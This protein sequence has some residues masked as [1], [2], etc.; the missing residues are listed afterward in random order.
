MAISTAAMRINN[1]VY[2]IV[3]LVL[4]LFCIATPANADGKQYKLLKI[5]PS[6]TEIIIGGKARGEG[7]VF[8]DGATIKWSSEDQ[9]IRTICLDNNKPQSFTAKAFKD[10]KAYSIAGYF[11]NNKMSQM[12]AGGLWTVLKGVVD[13]QRF[14]EKRIALVVGNSNYSSDIISSLTNPL[15]DASAVSKHLQSLGFDVWIAYDSK[16]DEFR[17][18]VDDFRKAVDNNKY[19]VSLLY[20]TGH[21]IQ[22]DK[23]DYLLPVDIALMGKAS[24]NMAV[25]ISD[26][27][28]HL[29]A[30]DCKTN[31]VFLNCCRDTKL[32]WRMSPYADGGV[33]Q[34]PNNFAMLQ[35]TRSGDPANDWINSSDENSPFAK[36]FLKHVGIPG[37]DLDE[38]FKQIRISVL[39]ATNKQQHPFPQ[40]QLIISVRRSIKKSQLSRQETFQLVP[41][42]QV[43]VL[44]LMARILIK[45]RIV[46]SMVFLLVNMSL[47]LNSMDTKRKQKR[48]K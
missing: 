37:R 6:N 19:N 11:L 22:V 48:L 3:L 12:S 29:S 47:R 28:D 17:Q 8:S 5:L 13:K 34:V 36:A 42:L 15:S 45:K 35:S 43:P 32:P 18:I 27:L 20:Y 31:L 26:L 4:A 2:S 40:N 14:P 24:L 38:T 44:L 41:H 1:S 23:V 10:R 9:V 46:P 30:T 39:E 25:S 21:G 16:M 7:Y 33:I